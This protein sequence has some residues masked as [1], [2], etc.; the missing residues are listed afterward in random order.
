MSLNTPKALSTMSE[1][2]THTTVR[3]G[4]R[5]LWYSERLWDLSQDLIPFDL[6][7]EN[8]KELDYDCWFGSIEPTMREVAKHSKRIQEADL[9]YPII[10]NDDGSLMDGGHRIC[11]ALMEG[12][13][14][15]QAVQFDVMPE[16]DQIID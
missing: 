5:L 10:L 1:P 13:S 7:I 12:Q 9:S 11:K 2:K 15:I 14:S 6:P 16:P 8:I 4:R 3:E